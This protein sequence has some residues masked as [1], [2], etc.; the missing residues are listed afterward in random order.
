MQRDADGGL[1]LVIQAGDPG[2]G[3]NWLPA[4]AGKDFY[5]VLRLYQPRPVH[6]EGAFVY[7]PV[8][9]VA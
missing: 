6:L 8:E 2:V 3:K 5:L 1:T 9:K 7:P 4:P